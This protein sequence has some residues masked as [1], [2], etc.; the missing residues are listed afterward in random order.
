M[1]KNDPII[2]QYQYSRF[3]ALKTGYFSARNF[4]DI[5]A[6]P[7]YQTIFEEQSK[8]LHYGEDDIAL[9]YLETISVCI[10]EHRL[11]CDAMKSYQKKWRAKQRLGEDLA[12][13]A[14]GGVAPLLKHIDIMQLNQVGHLSP[15]QRAQKL[16]TLQAEFPEIE[17]RYQEWQEEFATL[18]REHQQATKESQE[19]KS[20]YR[21]LS[22]Q[23]RAGKQITKLEAARYHRK[24]NMMVFLEHYDAIMTYLDTLPELP[25]TGHW[26][27]L[28][29]EKQKLEN[30]IEHSQSN[31]R[32][33]FKELNHRLEENENSFSAIGI[34]GSSSY[35]IQSVDR[36]YDA[37]KTAFGHLIQDKI[38]ALYSDIKKIPRFNDEDQDGDT[39]ISNG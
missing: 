7:L 31:L 15:D 30:Q 17:E 33:H 18:L 34:Q 2:P 37:T 36:W 39:E 1:N 35:T 27:N 25:M 32:W 10:Y 29:R 22:T 21:E 16:A 28:I 26:R 4:D 14:T 6:T 23:L 9:S 24:R 12:F 8:G 38:D 3:N 13:N 19:N 20:A 11:L 5:A